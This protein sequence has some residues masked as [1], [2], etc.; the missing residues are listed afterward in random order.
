MQFKHG[1]H[2]EE[3]CQIV[4]NSTWAVKSSPHRAAAYTEVITHK[5]A[6]ISQKDQ[7]ITQKESALAT[8]NE[9]MKQKDV[10][11]NDL[12]MRIRHAESER[13]ALLQQFNEKDVAVKEAQE[14]INAQLIELNI[15]RREKQQLLQSQLQATIERNLPWC[16]MI[17]AALAL[18]IFKLGSWCVCCCRKREPCI[19]DELRQT[20][21]M[22]MAMNMANGNR[23]E[24]GVAPSFGSGDLVARVTSVASHHDD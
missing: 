19:A 1:G 2:V 7:L 11:L 13:R 22:V 18:I 6:A 24:Q 10:A 9:V 15:Q 21:E 16:A 12:D 20:R 23:C 8:A 5:D 4:M 14:R 3:A 17:L